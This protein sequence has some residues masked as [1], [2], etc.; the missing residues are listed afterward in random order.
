MSY[1]DSPD[2]RR[3]RNLLSGER[4]NFKLRNLELENRED[5]GGT[6]GISDSSDQN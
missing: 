6:G 5:P 4:D 1:Q 2:V 3:Y